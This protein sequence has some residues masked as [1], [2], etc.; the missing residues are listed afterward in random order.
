[1]NS[2]LMNAL[3]VL[4]SAMFS[5]AQL[6][7]PDQEQTFILEKDAINVAFGAVLRQ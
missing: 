5:T 4:K 1:M 2:D 7:I 3:N 6:R